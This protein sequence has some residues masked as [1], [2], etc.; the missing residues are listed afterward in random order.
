MKDE[1]FLDLETENSILI[2]GKNLFHFNPQNSKKSN[3][4]LRFT[5]KK[6]IYIFMRFLVHCRQIID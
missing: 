3:N 4:F 5:E 1:I 2:I 6:L